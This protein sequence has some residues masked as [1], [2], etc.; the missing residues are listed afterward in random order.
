MAFADPNTLLPIFIAFVLGITVHEFAHAYVAYQMG[1]TL[2]YDQGRVTLDPRA[3]MTVM[4]TLLIFLIGFGWGKPVM[5]RIWDPRKRL[6]VSLAGPVSN[7]ILATFFGLFFRLGFAQVLNVGPEWFNLRTILFYIIFINVLLAVFNMIP[8]SPLDGSSVLAGILPDPYGNRLAAFN[9]RYPMALM[10]FL[11][12]DFVLV[13]RALGQSILWLI[14]G[15]P[16]NFL[17][18]LTAGL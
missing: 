7:I 5:H 12:I 1:D 10:L 8:L 16:I 17:L 2:P 14:L 3:H 18:S 6:W 15:P 4:G 13:Q 11:L 9:D